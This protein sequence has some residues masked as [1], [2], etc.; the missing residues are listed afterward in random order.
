MTQEEAIFN[1]Q[2]L[3]YSISNYFSNYASREDLYQAGY[4][5]IIKAYKNYDSN[6]NCKFSTYAYTY[7]LGEMRKVVREDKGVKVSREIS[8]LNL[9]IEKAYILLSQKLMRNPSITEIASYLEIDEYLV[10]E[11]INSTYSIKSVD[12]PVGDDGI[13]LH[14]VIGKCD[15]IDNLMMLKE[16]LSNLNP[17][18][19]ELISNRYMKDLTQSETSKLM[20]MSQVQVSRQEKKILT[21]LRSKMPV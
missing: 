1:N 20:N 15:D 2:N 6:I 8:K 19:L 13:M 16:S 21:K 9:K 7:I 5:G 17:S 11:A 14:E 3:V 18:E 12:E 4:M 10:S